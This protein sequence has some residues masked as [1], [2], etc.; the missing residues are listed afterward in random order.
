MPL[1]ADARPSVPYLGL[2]LRFANGCRA[3]GWRDVGF[4]PVREYQGERHEVTVAA[5]GFIWREKTY[6]SLSMIAREITG[7]SWNGPN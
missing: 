4:A 3:V 7:T 2:G 6:P 1:Q 5:D